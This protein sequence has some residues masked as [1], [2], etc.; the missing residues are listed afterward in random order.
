MA[1]QRDKGTPGDEVE[2]LR[3]E[4]G[5]IIEH[6]TIRSVYQPI[7]SLSDGEITGYEALTR[8]PDGSLLHSPLP[9][10]EWAEKLGV[11]YTLDRLARAKAIEG[12][13]MNN[14]KQ[15]LFL[16]VS[17]EILN[18]PLFAP[19]QTLE[20]LT[21]R[22]LRPSNVVFEITER[23]SIEDFASAQKILDHYRQQGY[24]IAIDDAGAGYSSLQAIAELNPD[25]IKVDK[26]LV[27]GMHRSKTKEYMLE[28]LVAF[29]DKLGIYLIAEGIESPDDLMKLTRM[30][31]HYG[32]GYLL[33]RP[34]G[35]ELKQ[36]QSD[37]KRQIA[38][39]RSMREWSGHMPAIGELAAPCQTFDARTPI[40]GVANY[41]KKHM[42]AQGAV[43]LRDNRPVGLIM[44][45]RLFQQL[46]GQY[47]YSLFWNR[48]IDQLMD[49]APL[50]V[51][52]SKPVEAVSKLATSRAIGHLYD[53]VIITSNDR[54]L[55]TA[56]VR[57]ILECITN[58]K[59]EKARVAN[60]LTGL[61][62]NLQINRE[63]KRRLTD[64]K[65]FSVIYA[66]LDF[67]KWYNDR[68]GFHKGDQLIQFTADCIQHSLHLLGAPHDFVGHIGGDDFIAVTACSDSEKIC[69]EMIRRFDTGVVAFYEAESWTYVE[70]RHGN[71]VESDGVT[72]SL[73]LVVCEAGLHATPEQISQ[74]AARLKKQSKAHR[75][76]VVFCDHVGHRISM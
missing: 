73:S 45:E 20:L 8:G 11:L 38:E 18:D 1:A 28:T 23:S 32:Q 4:L 30:G 61:P 48:P 74:T 5:H 9:L 69:Q 6:Q 19:G 43:I 62:G 60:P 72:L 53:L 36:I 25:Y 22:G 76:S 40:S 59:M 12:V 27:A 68:Y 52:D 15:L 17:A 71:R 54:L 46:A 33:G 49:E 56:S 75:G 16:N 37:I 26:S 31:V 42:D 70:D 44:R 24:R 35:Q 7:V 64:G 66:D 13:R 55:G 41:F 10:F 51:D 63:I 14:D 29:A 57:T 3:Q 2:T 50:I 47:G 21:A 34:S 65:R 67:F 58:V 39:H